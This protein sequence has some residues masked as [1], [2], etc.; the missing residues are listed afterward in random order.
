M[1]MAIWYVK[2][3]KTFRDAL[4]EVEADSHDQAVDIVVSQLS[5]DGDVQVMDATMTPTEAS[6]AALVEANKEKDKAQAVPAKK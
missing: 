2:Y 6:M 4:V 5:N 3:R 1:Q